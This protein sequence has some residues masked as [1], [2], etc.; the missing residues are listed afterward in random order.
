MLIS[1]VEIAMARSKE[2]GAQIVERFSKNLPPASSTPSSPAKAP[3]A[4]FGKSEPK[5][6]GAPARKRRR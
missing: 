3:R 4:A 1:A 5:R 2:I 6:P